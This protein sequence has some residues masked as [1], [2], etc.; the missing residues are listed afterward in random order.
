MKKSF[1]KRTSIFL[2]ISIIM[3]S[4]PGLNFAEKKPIKNSFI[5]TQSGPFFNSLLPWIIPISIG[6]SKI[7]TSKNT[8]PL[9]F[10]RPLAEMSIPRPSTGD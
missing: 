1:L 2:F 3:M 6:K 4:L 5:L 8:T 10:V 9:L 7:I